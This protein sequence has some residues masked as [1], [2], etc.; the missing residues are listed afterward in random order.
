MRD[1]GQVQGLP[2]SRPQSMLPDQGVISV[3]VE[4]CWRKH[5]NYLTLWMIGV[6]S[7]GHCFPVW[8]NGFIPDGKMNINNHE[9]ASNQLCYVL[10][11]E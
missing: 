1:Y 3:F 7:P 9:P 2:D 5:E 8:K 11:A 6:F 10:T 4:Y